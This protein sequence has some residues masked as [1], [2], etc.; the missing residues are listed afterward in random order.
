MTI[1][2]CRRDR[3][4]SRP[5]RA[6]ALLGAA[7]LATAAAPPAA[8]QIALGETGLTLTAT[9]AL[10][11]DYV[12]RGIS[13]TRSRPAIQG[14]AEIAHESGL[15]L[16]AFASNVAFQGTNARQEVDAFAGYRFEALGIAWDLGG[17]LYNYPGY[18]PG[19][20]QFRLEYFEAA[21]RASREF[22]PVKLLGAFHWSPNFQAQ[23]GNGFYLEGGV[24]V[25]LP[26][27]F[28][29][30]GRLAYQWIDRNPRFGTPDYLW[31]SVGVSRPVPGG[32]TLAL[33]WYDTTLSRADCFGGQKVC[34]GRVVF[35]VSR[36]F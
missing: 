14:T 17:I 19:P 7:V 9:P 6:L 5:A 31:Y 4:S 28:T 32:F 20:G 13:Q 12:F 30:S 1:R 22:G 21:L 23:S 26:L 8:A 27:E 33:G 25:S 24:D 36:A 34:A 11:T 18:D 29:A 35:S 10:V 16:G 15:Y 2:P 3:R